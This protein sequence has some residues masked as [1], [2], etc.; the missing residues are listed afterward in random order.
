MPCSVVPT[1]TAAHLPRRPPHQAGRAR[2][3]AQ[4]LAAGVPVYFAVAP[5]PGASGA[6][7]GGE[8]ELGQQEENGAVAAQELS[9]RSAERQLRHLVMEGFSWEDEVP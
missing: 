8:Q 2:T 4:L 5:G 9:M 6:A 3:A 1:Q 7:A